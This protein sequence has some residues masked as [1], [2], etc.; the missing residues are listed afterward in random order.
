[1][2]LHD[3]LRQFDYARAE[4]AYAELGDSDLLKRLFAQGDTVYNRRKL[5]EELQRL[6]DR[7]AAK[8]PVPTRGIRPR[9]RADAP[10]DV[11]TIEREWRRDLSEARRLHMGLAEQPD[12]AARYGAAARILDLDDAVRAAWRKLDYYDAHGTLPPPPLPPVNLALSDL[13]EMERR[14]N[15][16][17][18]YLS[19]SKDKA[20]QEEK[21]Q[22]WQAEI[23]ELE[24]RLAE[25]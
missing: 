9:D 19:R 3:L 8:L 12:Q 24:K 18:T 14:R 1:M 22:A 13:V 11:L 21:R 6:A 7:G 25:R 4:A 15:T 20:G 17:R 23:H 16:L 2:Q 5:R 10:G